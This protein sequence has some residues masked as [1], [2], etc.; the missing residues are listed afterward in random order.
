MPSTSR[1]VGPILNASGST[2]PRPLAIGPEIADRFEAPFEQGAGHAHHAGPQNL[3]RVEAEGEALLAVGDAAVVGERPF[4]PAED[5]DHPIAHLLGEQAKHV[6][7]T[8]HPERH[9]RVA[10]LAVVVRQHAER[11][12]QVSGAENAAPHQILTEP[13]ARRRWS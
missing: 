12:L 5:V 2:R 3:E 7:R 6:E 10:Q 13:L 11:E 4:G 1:G 9:E 8:Q